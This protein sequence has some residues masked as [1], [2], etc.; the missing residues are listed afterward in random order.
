MTAGQFCKNYWN[1]KWK[2]RKWEAKQRTSNQ[3][4]TKWTVFWCL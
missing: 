3:S 4:Q 1:Q 2:K